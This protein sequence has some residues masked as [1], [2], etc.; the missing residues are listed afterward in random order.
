MPEKKESSS[1]EVLRHV[2]E[3]IVSGEILPSEVLYETTVAVDTGLSRTPV[4]EALSRLVSEGFLE[5]TKGRRGYAVPALTREDMQN[6]YHA[7]ECLEQKIASLAAER[8]VKS[9]VDFLKQISEEETRVA[10]SATRISPANR[11]LYT[12]ENEPYYA[13]DANVRFHLGV[14]RVARNKYLERVYE[15]AYWRSHLYTYYIIDRL[16]FPPEVED[17]F[18][19]RKRANRGAQEH[20]EL[21]DA[22]AVRDGDSA[23]R[24]T[25]KHLRDTTYYTIAFKYPEVLQNL[26]ANYLAND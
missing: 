3:K 20:R 26:P 25:L 15:T 14:A 23:A 7:R 6:V 17:V 5:Q 22:I 19:R 11:T 10:S 2:V 18:Q 1:N 13:V 21:I 12:R 16:P 9:D 4:R 8:A 24:L